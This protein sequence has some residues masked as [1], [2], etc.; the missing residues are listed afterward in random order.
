MGFFDDLMSSPTIQ[1][2]L[3][4]GSEMNAGLMNPSPYPTDAP[5]IRTLGSPPMPPGPSAPVNPPG[6]MPPQPQG[7]IAPTI[8]PGLPYGGNAPP[9][10]GPGGV[11][12]PPGGA[13]SP[14]QLMTGGGNQPPPMPS[15][16][17]AMLPPN[18]T[19]T[20]TPPDAATM[21]PGSTWP[22]G[23]GPPMPITPGP[24]PPSPQGGIGGALGIDLSPDRRQLLM[25]SLGKGL[26]AASQN[27]NKPGA[28][29]FA[30]GAGG[31]LE[32]GTAEADKQFTQKLQTKAQD[33][34][35]ASG[36]FK[37]V[38]AQQQQN[39]MEAYRQAQ[40]K[41]LSARADSL[42]AGGPG[43]GSN[44][45]QATD[46]GKVMMIEGA[47]DK[48]DDRE[49]KLLALQWK[50]NGSTPAQQ[51]T[52]L[53]SLAQ[54]KAEESARRYKAIGLDHDAAAKVRSRGTSADNPFDTKG[55]TTDMFDKMV[56]MG[57]YYRDRSGVV[58]QRTQPPAEM[59]QQP[60]ISPQAN[61]DDATA[62]QPAA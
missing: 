43:K 47:L 10:V 17:P 35:Q 51:K 16:N 1:G 6:P 30:G 50:Q 38:L 20:A 12:L 58:R 42:K 37:D 18:A 9:A 49:K 25:A 57:G 59:Q 4:V 34:T 14:Q 27:W 54:R 23:A 46:Y 2:I 24:A 45:W 28:A 56:P 7:T 15:P 41:Y 52:D 53:D 62:M 21:P 5:P 22:N 36:L 19:P 32:G 8:A 55:M 33:F 31:A 44:A 60:P 48:W 13:P 3:G 39:N 40:A 61:Y 29:A 11:V 26:T